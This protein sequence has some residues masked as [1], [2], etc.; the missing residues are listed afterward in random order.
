M[1]AGFETNHFLPIIPYR[2]AIYGPDFPGKT[3]RVLKKN[4]NPA[5]A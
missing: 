5:S 1:G 4:K 2:E 3:F